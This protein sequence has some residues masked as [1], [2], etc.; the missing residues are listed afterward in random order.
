MSNI[1]FFAGKGGVGKTTASIIFGFK[2]GQKGK[3]K[4]VSIDPAH[5]LSDILNIQLKKDVEKKIDTNFYVKEISTDKKLRIEKKKIKEKL[6]KIYNYL[7]ALNLETIID[8]LDYSPGFEEQ[9]ILDAIE[10]EIQ[11][12]D[13]S[14]IIFDSP[15]T[16]LFL[17]VIY[18]LFASVSWI[19]KLLTLRKDIVHAR[20]VLYEK[21]IEDPILL[22]LREKY[23][24]YRKLTNLIKNSVF[25]VVE[26]GTIPAQKEKNRIV[27]ALNKIGLKSVKTFSNKG[28]N[29]P[30]LDEPYGIKNLKQYARFLKT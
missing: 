28:K 7:T 17:R 11:K 30:L 8:I 26:D 2:K 19:E 6:K 14:F 21:K 3:T 4:L 16:A 29:L 25:F 15:P 10:E 23:E 9:A 12:N 24:K 27:K 5:N 13:F 1:Y 20:E 18:T 22:W